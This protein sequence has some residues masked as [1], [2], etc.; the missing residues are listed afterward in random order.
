MNTSRKRRRRDADIRSVA[1]ARRRRRTAPLPS[2]YRP[3]SY[4]G[5]GH[6][7]SRPQFS[8]L[9]PWLPTTGSA[10]T[11]QKGCT[12]TDQAMYFGAKNWHFYGA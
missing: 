1:E 8:R 12:F 2:P 6:Y 10:N 5:Q 9:G 3:T 11:V 7:R 4:Q